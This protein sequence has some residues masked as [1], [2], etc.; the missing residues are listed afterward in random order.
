M[1]YNELTQRGT[2]DFPIELYH[3]EKNHTRYEM[4]AHWH[5]EVELIRVLEGQ[6]RCKFNNQNYL[7]QKGDV[8]IVNSEYVHSAMPE[9][10]VYECIVFHMDFLYPDDSDCKFFVDNILNH[11]YIVKEYYPF[12]NSEVHKTVNEIFDA[13]KNKTS[14]Y[15]FLVIGAF[16]RLFGLIS[17]NKLYAHSGGT[18]FA[19][20]KNVPKLKN[21]LTYI[22]KNYDKH[23]YLEDMAAVAGMSPKY[24]CAFFKEMTGRTPVEYLKIYRIEKA[25]RKL[26][27]TDEPVTDIAYSC[28]FNDLSYFIKTFKELKS[29]TPAQYR[30]R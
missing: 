7:A 22:R 12:E 23:I 2:D 18:T 25:S 5:S 1:I 13:L 29:I 10:C 21:I 3:I 9:D 16:Y 8:L 4:T 20:D 15:K 30:K 11:E 17:D 26:L 19:T 27:N 24:F 28:G 6:L 14:G